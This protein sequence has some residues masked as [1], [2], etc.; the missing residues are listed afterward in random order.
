MAERL[1]PLT[2]IETTAKGDTPVML[3]RPEQ[4]RLRKVSD[5]L[6]LFAALVGMAVVV[7]PGVYG[8]GTASGISDDITNAVTT[9]PGLIVNIVRQLASLVVLA[10][11]LYLLGDLA[12]RRRWRGLLIASATGVIAVIVTNVVIANASQ[13]FSLSLY[14]YLTDTPGLRQPAPAAMPV[15]AAVV[16]IATVEGMATRSRVS[17]TLWASLI[18]LGAL[19]LI[20]Y[21]ATLPAL[22]LSVL[23]GYALG[24]ALRYV[25]GSDNP[26]VEAS[27]IV[28]I[29]RRSGLDIVEVHQLDDNDEGRS[30]RFRLRSGD[31]AIAQVFDPDRRAAQAVSQVVRT[32]R[33]RN[34]VARRAQWS[35]RAT[36]QAS[37]APVLMANVKDARTPKLLAAVEVERHTAVYVE[38]LPRGLTTLESMEAGA[39]TDEM[40]DSLWG[41]LGVLQRASVSHEG[42][43]P[44]SLAVDS[45][46][47]GWL[48]ELYRGELAS[49]PLRLRLDRT[50]LF[51]SMALCVG[52]KRAMA[53]AQREL[54]SDEV[55]NMLAFI[56][57]VALNVPLRAALKDQP[58]LI[59]E[60]RDSISDD[61]TDTRAE[62]RFERIRPQT[63]V[64]VFAG[65]L[66][67][68]ALAGQ[69]GSVDFSSLV[70]GVNWEWAAVALAGSALSYAG[71][72]VS[73]S[74]FSPVKIPLINWVLTQ[75]AAS[76]VVLVAPPAV[77]SAGMN[78]RL[79]QKAGVKS[80]LAVASVGIATAVSVVTSVS[81]LI[82]MALVSQANPAFELSA[83]SGRVVFV[84]LGVIALIAVMLAI[85]YTRN[86]IVSRVEP[87]WKS[88]IP[89]L[90]DV[91]R[92]PARLARGA[93]G[94][95]MTT[96][97]YALAIY[98]SVQAYGGSLNFTAGVLIVLGSGLVGTVAP[99]PGGLGAVEA[100]LVA[101]LRAAGTSSTIALS[102]ALMYR[103]VTFWL[104]T[105]PGW[106]SFRILQHRDAI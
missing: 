60:I 62:P 16:G 52:A 53:A 90:L 95:L 50:E 69:L 39:I 105:I 46:R 97:G 11:P 4:P 31:M 42:L 12:W 101:G 71:A 15:F 1:E 18:A 45:S 37:A 44:R 55:A 17:A 73:A 49:S 36:L 80:A 14:R 76:F 102:A 100:A 22:V 10:L 7:L 20:D 94:N 27:R 85:P 106:V 92:D 3:I 38:E 5:L 47:Q 24:L 28:D 70:T 33:L 41:Q 93:T 26:R 34:W 84:V 77:G 83:P 72:T 8:L 78:A 6:R 74:S 43:H 13:W 56:Q 35:V 65:T 67:V 2:S 88:T 79:M 86:A 40:L 30:F 51:L 9:I 81:T 64:A 82:V 103:T 75:L 59:E 57:P 61:E 91:A 19:R 98:G 89:R 66:A 68:Y 104:P 96:F 25:V 99:T 48:L 87:I 21:T 32:L 58:D 29:V 23:F 63:L 54:S